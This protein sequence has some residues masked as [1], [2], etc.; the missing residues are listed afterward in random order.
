MPHCCCLK[1]KGNE[2]P[3]GIS[4]PSPLRTIAGLDGPDHRLGL[5][6]HRTSHQWTSSYVAT[7]K[8]WFTHRHLILKRIS[9][10]VFLR[11]Q[12]TSGNNLALLSHKSVCAAPLS[13][14]YQGRCPYVWTPALKRYEIQLFFFFSFLFPEYVSG[15]AWFPTLV[16]PTF[17]V[18]NAARMHLRHAVASQ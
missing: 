14:I 11:Q 13:P 5:P 2:I 15:F 6:C 18:D 3:F 16:K 17:T 12:Q 9:S 10:S 8:L 1:D 4:I 7:L